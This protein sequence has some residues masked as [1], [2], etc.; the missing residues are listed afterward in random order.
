MNEHSTCMETTSAFSQVYGVRMNPTTC[1][2]IPPV[3]VNN[4]GLSYR[5]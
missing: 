5:Q 4:V 3:A 2:G 1:L